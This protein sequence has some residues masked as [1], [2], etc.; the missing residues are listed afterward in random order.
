VDLIALVMDAHIPAVDLESF[1]R[2][3]ATE[4]A[5]EQL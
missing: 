2:Q 1:A 3:D 5:A 4:I